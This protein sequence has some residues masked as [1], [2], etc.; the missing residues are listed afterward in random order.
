MTEL[1]QLSLSLSYNNF[2]H[3][4]IIP[5]FSLITFVNDFFTIIFKPVFNPLTI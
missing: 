5:Q 3:L 2:S 4:I 1:F